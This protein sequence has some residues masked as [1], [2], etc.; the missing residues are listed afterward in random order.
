MYFDTALFV[1]TGSMNTVC[2]A[3]KRSRNMRAANT[4]DIVRWTGGIGSVRNV[5]R[6]FRRNFIFKYNRKYRAT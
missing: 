3:G 2:S 6:I 5:S 4:A 1:P